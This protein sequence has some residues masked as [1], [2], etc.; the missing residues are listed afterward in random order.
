MGFVQLMAALSVFPLKTLLSLGAARE[1]LCF[2]PASCADF[3]CDYY[4]YCLSVLLFVHVAAL[5][6]AAEQENHDSEKGDKILH[7]FLHQNFSPPDSGLIPLLKYTDKLDKRDKS[8]GGYSRT[9]VEMAR[10]PPTKVQ[11]SVPCCGRTCPNYC[12]FLCV[13]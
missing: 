8:T 10:P 5:L 1:T 2:G 6:F 7:V 12:V 4:L 13:C 3:V 11:N 9:T